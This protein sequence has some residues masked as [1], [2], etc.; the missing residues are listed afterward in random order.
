VPS[1]KQKGITTRQLQQSLGMAYMGTGLYRQNV[2]RARMA[3]VA[4]AVG[5]NEQ[6]AM[7]ASSDIYWDEIVSIKPSGE[8]Q[9]Y[10]LT[11]PG[12]SNFV[13][14]DMIVHNSIEQDADVVMFI[15]RDDVYDQQTERK[16]VAEVIVAKHRN[17][18]TGSIELYFKNQ[19]A[20]FANAAKREINV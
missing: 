17:G 7:L 15:Y 5:G 4:R 20:Q 1:I 6:L 2:S 3:R 19:L 9:V 10:D 13:A 11:V 18:P 14:N 8:E 12:P 16:N